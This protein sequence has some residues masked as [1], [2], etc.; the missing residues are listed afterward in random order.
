MAHVLGLSVD[1]PMVATATREAFRLYARYWHE[2][3]QVR[4]MSR[5][6]ILRRFQA[7][8]LE[9][10]DRA[11]EAG[12]GCIAVL[13]HMGNWDA[14]GRW[15]TERG[16]AVVS[17]A[18][19]LR[20]RRLFEMFLRHREELG[21]RIVPLTKEG[22]VGQQLA[23]LLSQNQLV[24]LVADRDLSGRGVE[25]EMF[26]GVRKLPAGPALLSLTSGAP[27]LVCPIHTTERGWFCRLGEPL[28]ITPT[29]DRRRDVGAITR[30]IADEFERAIAVN[31]PDWHMFQP[32]WSRAGRAEHR[33]ASNEASDPA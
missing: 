25:V 9:N 24:A 8:G 3:F 16:Y 10:V 6:E 27:I 19:E 30:L 13:P 29:G 11:L 28:E 22:H 31:P 4:R 17:V 21:M 26:G 20:P 5:A 1:D 7:E 33:A 2:T 12:K 32:G 15:L 14:A 18:E 23:T